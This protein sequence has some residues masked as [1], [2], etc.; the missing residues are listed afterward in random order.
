MF[1]GNIAKWKPEEDSYSKVNIDRMEAELAGWSNPQLNPEKIGMK[2]SA[3]LIKESS[4]FGNKPY[5]LLWA[6]NA[7]WEGGDAPNDWHPNAWNRMK[8]LYAGDLAKMQ[9]LST[10]T[11]IVFANTPEHNV[12]IHEPKAVVIEINNL[13]EKLRS[14]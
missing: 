9:T 5:I 3:K 10:D 12:F 11:K 6:K 1:Y 4:D 7:I 2:S 8:N 14:N 13:I